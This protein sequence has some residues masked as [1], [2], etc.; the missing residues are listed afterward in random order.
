MLLDIFPNLEIQGVEYMD[1]TL[2]KNSTEE[3]MEDIM[4]DMYVLEDG[5]QGSK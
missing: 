2:L 5:H 1:M 4:E 3:D